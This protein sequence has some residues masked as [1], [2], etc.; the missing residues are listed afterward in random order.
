MV[1]VDEN[2]SD[3]Q[4]STLTA[5]RTLL[6]DQ[7][8]WQERTTDEI[9]SLNDQNSEILKQLTNLQRA[10]SSMTDALG[11]GKSFWNF[12]RGTSQA[13]GLDEVSVKLARWVRQSEKVAAQ[14]HFLRSLYYP[15][16][17]TRRTTIKVAHTHTFEWMFHS[18]SADSGF[19]NWLEH[20]S[21]VFWISGKAGSGKSTLMK[22]LYD[23]PNTK[24][25]L[26]TWAGDKAI[27]TPNF[28]LW[29]AGTDLQKSQEGLL[30]TLLWEVL[31]QFP[32]LVPDCFPKQWSAYHKDGSTVH[33]WTYDELL[34]AFSHLAQQRRVAAKFCFFVDGLDEYEGDCEQIVRLLADLANKSPNF[35]ICVSSRPWNVFKNA[36]GG[37]MFPKLRLED[38]TRADIRAYVTDKLGENQ[39]YKNLQAQQS[40][41]N[42]FVEE[43]V[44][45]ANGVF[46]WVH[47]VVHSLLDGLRN[48]DRLSDLEKRLQLLPT[49]LKGYFQHMWESLGGAYQQQA[50]ETF[51]IKLAAERP[52]TLMTFSMLDEEEDNF[53]I[54]WETH[55]MTHE[56]LIH[57]H[58]VMKKRL[59]ARCKDLLEIKSAWKDDQV[60][61]ARGRRSLDNEANARE[62]F[63]YRVEF[64]HRTV[65]DFLTSE[66]MQS[67]MTV[68]VPPNFDPSRRLCLAFLAQIKRIS[69]T[70][71]FVFHNGPMSSLVDD[72]VSCARNLPVTS[73]HFQQQTQLMLELRNVLGIC[74]DET[75][76]KASILLLPTPQS[77]HE[78]A[79]SLELD[80]LIYSV[81]KGL[82][83]F[84]EDQLQHEFCSLPP[85]EFALLL[86][87]SLHLSDTSSS[88]GTPDPSMLQ[89]LLR[90]MNTSQK[91]LLRSI[92]NDFLSAAAIEW[93]E[94]PVSTR[95]ACSQIINRLLDDNIDD[96]GPGLS[97]NLLWV[98]ILLIPKS[99]WTTCSE[100]LCD[101]LCNAIEKILS[102][103]IDSNAPYKNSTLWGHFARSI[104]ETP[105]DIQSR[106]RLRS[107]L[108]AF[109]K[110][111]VDCNHRV[112]RNRTTVAFQGR[113]LNFPGSNAVFQR[114]RSLYSP[115]EMAEIGLCK[116]C[117][118]AGKLAAKENLDKSGVPRLTG[119]QS[120]AWSKWF[121]RPSV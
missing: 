49:S 116:E 64:L 38:L 113:D 53:A 106:S 68:K 32:N 67:E 47:L 72:L 81:R 101:S 39:L 21:G 114:L 97:K 58:E 22:F 89:L 60:F 5:L 83:I 2:A 87:T 93:E 56:E 69:M 42:H 76:T 9:Q 73:N 63:K 23:H 105:V 57:R 3:D 102:Q 34:E 77:E 46:L 26:R 35:K 119:S 15:S 70:P 104:T 99:N 59:N 12:S 13:Q 30:R 1:E 40:S 111:G 121:W 8:K 78:S 41:R 108:H 51:S 92:W 10:T 103:D 100:E 29:K 85:Q 52:L 48:E 14:Q 24:A 82:L 17:E 95:I 16:M 43:V 109:V 7:P 62:F 20:Q 117:C 118:S 4:S 36:F 28:F 25:A 71:R 96:I 18:K 90:N 107:T 27:V 65:I 94:Y 19:R 88:M 50:A 75:S 11:N 31:M 33:P 37:E 66:K 98:D 86:R 84:V 6:M 54:K 61:P 45:R 112:Q 80:F 110:R 55:P 115:A 74:E 120:F 79:R 91:A 44:S